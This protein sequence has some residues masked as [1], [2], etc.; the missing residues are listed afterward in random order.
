MSQILQ[1]NTSMI[2]APRDGGS[3]RSYQIGLSLEREGYQ[4]SRLAVCTLRP[5]EIEDVKEPIIN[6]TD[7]AFWWSRKA[8]RAYPWLAMLSD[9]YLAD[10]LHAEPTKLRAFRIFMEQSAPDLIILEGPWLWP[11]VR[12]LDIIKS[13]MTPVIYSSQNVE[14]QLKRSILEARGIQGAESTLACIEHLERDLAAHAAGISACTS[15]D[16]GVFSAWGAHD[17]IVAGNGAVAKDRNHLRGCLPLDVGDQVRYGLIVG[18]AHPPNIDGF[19]RLA[20]PALPFLHSLQK[21]V[22]VGTMGVALNRYSNVCGNP[23]LILMGEVDELVL[24]ALICN[25]ACIL[26]PVDYGGGSNLKTAEAIM[27]GCRIVATTHS[28]RGFETFKTSPGIVLA[29]TPEEFRAA[30]DSALSSHISESI[31]Q[32][33]ESIRWDHTLEPLLAL[34]K[35]T[36]LLQ[37]GI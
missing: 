21:I 17:V 11:V 8:R 19:L 1:L 28:L 29:D 36:L 31:R 4:I 16:A 6:L 3:I 13:R 23:N 25:A 26:I 7:S 30:L 12:E 34:V 18:S 27:A 20:L 2:S 10:A 37:G 24:D 35:K 32:N 9:Y 22:V 33:R 14:A 15:Q 5:G